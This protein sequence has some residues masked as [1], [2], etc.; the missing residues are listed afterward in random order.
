MDMKKGS[1]DGLPFLA[2]LVETAG[3]VA[4]LVG[5]FEVEEFFEEGS[6]FDVG[7]DVGE[8]GETHVATVAED[9]EDATSEGRYVVLFEVERL[10]DGWR[11]LGRLP[12]H[13]IQEVLGR[14]DQAGTV[15]TDETVATVAAVVGDAPGEG[16]DVASVVEGD[17]CGD[18]RATFLLALR[19][20][21]GIGQ[22]CDDAVA[23]EEVAA[24][25][26]SAGG[27]FGEK[28]ATLLNHLFGYATVVVGV[29]AVEAVSDHAE[30][31]DAIFEGCLMRL[32][33]DAQGQSAD[34]DD[35]GERFMQ[36]LHET[37]DDVA[38]I[39]RA[40]ACA[41]N[42]DDM[43]GLEVDIAELEEDCGGIG[44]TEE[45]LGVAFLSIDEWLDV[46]GFDEVE[47]ASGVVEELGVLSTI[48][49]H[50]TDGTGLQEQVGFGIKDGF[51]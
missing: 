33:V 26:R 7:K 6:A 44:T 8:L 42:A 23:G 19:H 13:R 11:L 4:D 18:E 21:D 41:D 45:A 49:D 37:M 34:D 40:L 10:L 36:F 27:I 35:V 48:E 25:E 24:F 29:D 12:I 16:E 5:H 31:R 17:G 20:K 30:G 50:L 3:G 1:L 43:F 9:V 38:T 51:G 39:L 32:D 2:G 47:F 22:T 46:V 28:T 15:E 14:G